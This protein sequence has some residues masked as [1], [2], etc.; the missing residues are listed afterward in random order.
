[1]DILPKFV[2]MALD[3]SDKEGDVLPELKEQ[4]MP[5]YPSGLCLS[6]GNEQLDKLNMDGK[7]E[8]GDMV[9]LH[10]IG[11]VTSYSERNSES[12]TQCRAEIQLTHIACENENS[13]NNIEQSK[14][15]AP[16]S[17]YKKMYNSEGY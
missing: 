2:D 3:L 7:P 13:E 15:P 8:V 9:H 6:I 16:K 5:I 1:M 14:M 4:S 10:A 17:P 11:I 12:G